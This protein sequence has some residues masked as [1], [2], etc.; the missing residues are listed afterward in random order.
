M[1]HVPVEQKTEQH[2]QPE[3]LKSKDCPKLM[4]RH[5]AP[6]HQVDKLLR[7]KLG[8]NSVSKS[9]VQD[10]NIQVRDNHQ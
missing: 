10:L 8:A 2:P 7:M 6:M 1:L 5:N 4:S 3:R 9:E